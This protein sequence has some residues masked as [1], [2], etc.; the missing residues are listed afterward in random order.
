MGQRTGLKYFNLL[1]SPTCMK[2]NN[3]VESWHKQLKTAYLHRKKNRRVDCLIYILVND[4][5]PDFIQNISR[6]TLNLGRMGPE[7]RRKRE[8]DVEVINEAVVPT[9]IKEFADDQ[10]N[11]FK[12]TSF[13][14]EHIKYDIVVENEAMTSR[15]CQDFQWSKTA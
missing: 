15:T 6:I 8:L 13:T 10:A 3:Y 14:S 11:T 5:E 9:M 4:V 12:I 2:T 1:S 7:E